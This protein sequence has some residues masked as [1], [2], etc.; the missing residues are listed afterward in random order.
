MAQ[1][2]LNQTTGQKQKLKILTKGIMVAG[3]VSVIGVYIYATMFFNAAMID[4]SLAETNAR[5]MMGYEVKAGEMMIHYLWHADDPLKSVKGPDAVS[6]G[7]EVTVVSENSGIRGLN[8]GTGKKGINLEIPALRELN[9]EGIDISFD[10]KR[11]E[12]NCDFFSRGSCFNFGMKKGRL[13]I[14]YSVRVCDNKT[15][16]VTEIT[17]YEI[18]ADDE[19]RN[20]RF[21]YNPEKGLGEIFVNGIVIWSHLVNEQTPLAW[22]KSDNI[23]IGKNMKGDGSIKAIFANLIVRAAPHIN[24]I[25]VRLLSFEAIAR[26]NDV[27]IR[28]FTSREM[29][30]DSFRIERSVNGEDFIFINNV[31]A[32]GNSSSLQAYALIDNDPLV[33]ERAYYRMVLTN[34]PLKSISVPVIGFRYRKDHIENMPVQKIEAKIKEELKEVIQ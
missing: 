10:F 1:K 28:W 4:D 18:P 31:K 7:K 14:S 29:D 6:L 33:N 3:G 24:K 34:K 17:K 25:P 20:Y 15:M 8:P 5:A 30:T 21:L 32:A 27:M 11:A 12:D 9:S 2:K 16:Q 22:K 13:I 19:F 23:I 26:E